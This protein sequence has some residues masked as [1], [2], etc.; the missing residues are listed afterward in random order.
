MTFKHNNSA[1]GLPTSS[2][3]QVGVS[4]V[5]NKNLNERGINIPVPNEEASWLYFECFVGTILDSGIVVHNR[6]PQVDKGFDTLSNDSDTWGSRQFEKMTTGVNLLCKDQYTDIVQRMGHA[7]YWF[8][9]WGRALRA[10]FQIPIPSLKTIGGVPTVP[11]DKNPQWAYNAIVPGGNIGGMIIW[12]AEW[13][14]W[15]T[16]LTPPISQY[17]P[18]SDP[19]G[20][21]ATTVSGPPL[22]TVM[23]APFSQP[24][25][26]AVV[27]S[28]AAAVIAV[29]GAIR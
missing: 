10:K 24:D 2:T 1:Y 11:Y 26:N 16:T 8:R 15:Y 27:S 25:D 14:L 20:H 18:M 7:R 28:P 29:A 3:F 23:Q 4:D 9:L 12:R 22:P 6:L 21:I 5:D 19:S 17:I 13:S